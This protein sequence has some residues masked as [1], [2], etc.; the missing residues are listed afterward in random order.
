MRV[1]RLTT[2]NSELDNRDIGRTDNWLLEDV[3][4][5]VDTDKGTLVQMETHLALEI[6]ENAIEN[7][8][9]K[10][11]KRLLKAVGVLRREL[12]REV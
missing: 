10:T 9:E 12:T 11:P 7:L 3:G 6:V 5:E 2:E 4:I 1:V 8:H